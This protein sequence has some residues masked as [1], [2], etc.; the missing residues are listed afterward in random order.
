MLGISGWALGTGDPH[1]IIMP[2]DSV[3]NKCGAKDTDFELYTYKHFTSLLT[4]T[5]GTPQ[6]Y[7]AVC[8]KECP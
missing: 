6:Q 7:Y 5:S 8:V 4:A 1:N 2:F 3:G